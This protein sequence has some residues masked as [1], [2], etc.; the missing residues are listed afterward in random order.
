LVVYEELLALVPNEAYKTYLYTHLVCS[1]HESKQTAMESRLIRFDK[2]FDT[3][4]IKRAL[5]QV[6]QAEAALAKAVRD[7]MSIKA[8]GRERNN[9]VEFSGFEHLRAHAADLYD[10][11][12]LSKTRASHFYNQVHELDLQKENIGLATKRVLLNKSIIACNVRVMAALKG[13]KY[14]TMASFVQALLHLDMHLANNF[15]NKRVRSLVAQTI[16]VIVRSIRSE[17]DRAC[18]SKCTSEVIRFGT[19]FPKLNLATEGVEAISIHLGEEIFSYILSLPVHLEARKTSYLMSNLFRNMA[20]CID[21]NCEKIS[22]AFGPRCRLIAFSLMIK[23]CDQRTACL[24]REYVRSRL[25]SGVQRGELRPFEDNQH[26]LGKCKRSL[27]D[28]L[29]EICEIY[30]LQAEYEWLIHDVFG[31]DLDLFLNE[32]EK[33][34][35]MTSVEMR[36][37]E[38]VYVELMTRLLEGVSNETKNP[39]MT[40]NGA[41]EIFFILKTCLSRA[42]KSGACRVVKSTFEII[43]HFLKEKARV[44]FYAS[45]KVE[46]S[47][48]NGLN[49]FRTCLIALVEYAMM[50]ARQYMFIPENLFDRDIKSLEA[51][52]T[53]VDKEFIKM[54]DKYNQGI[55]PKFEQSFNSFATTSYDEDDNTETERI[56][57]LRLLKMLQKELCSLKMSLSP[58]V[59]ASL[60]DRLILR[61]AEKIEETMA[62]LKIMSRH[63][64]LNFEQDIRFLTHQLCDMLPMIQVRSKFT[65]LLQIAFVLN[66]ESIEDLSLVEDDNLLTSSEIHNILRLR[67]DIVP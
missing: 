55:L 44:M 14:K 52:Q 3:A 8:T 63:G 10:A 17:F 13:T 22:A 31:V 9:Q 42:L 38:E 24:L 45:E 60:A 36:R 43:V 41:D 20:S 37:L 54:I 62:R 25:A 66:M 11:S 46:H 6:V 2:D 28:Q 30:R 35:C 50:T 58:L 65:R 1:V 40:T 7:S 18:H 23:E 59:F 16:A 19:L 27:S 64:C 51:L 4:C 56:W 67:V 49:S 53:D 48:L 39:I 57:M 33:R 29:E 32:D 34:G 26:Q 47:S 61:V 15:F 12:A 5:E 21:E